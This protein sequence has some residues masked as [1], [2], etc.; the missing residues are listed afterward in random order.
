MSFNYTVVTGNRAHPATGTGTV[1]RSILVQ[2]LS[3]REITAL[4]SRLREACLDA[5]PQS[6]A[7]K[8]LLFSRAEVRNSSCFHAHHHHHQCPRC[9]SPLFFLP[10]PFF[11]LFFP[12]PKGD[13]QSSR[14]SWMAPAPCMRAGEKCR[15][16]R[17]TTSSRLGQ[18]GTRTRPE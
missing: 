6:P 4:A 7:A 14:V 1:C 5:A 12:F 16:K 3:A 10:F 15:E 9:C 2:I 11:T 8:I 17:E 13:G 18:W